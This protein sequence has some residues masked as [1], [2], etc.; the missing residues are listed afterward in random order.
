[1]SK[2]KD[3]PLRNKMLELHKSGVDVKF[4]GEGNAQVFLVKIRRGVSLDDQFKLLED[5]RVSI[6]ESVESARNQKLTRQS[7][8]E[9]VESMKKLNR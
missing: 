5:I 7:A 4:I 6:N 8:Q 1:M 9:F 2:A 3:S